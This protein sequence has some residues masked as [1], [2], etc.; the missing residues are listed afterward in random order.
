M[1][2]NLNTKAMSY[3][4]LK[5]NILL[6]RTCTAISK[7]ERLANLP[8]TINRP[9]LSTLTKDRLCIGDAVCFLSDR[10]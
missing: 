2:H 7:Q 3:L 6:Y 10:N 8:P 1:L 5:Q 9:V 4:K